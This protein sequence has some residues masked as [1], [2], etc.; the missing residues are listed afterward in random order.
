MNGSFHDRHNHHTNGYSDSSL[1]HPRTSRRTFHTTQC[2]SA[3]AGRPP[4]SP[5]PSY[6]HLFPTTC[7][8]PYRRQDESVHGFQ[9]QAPCATG[10]AS[11]LDSWQ[12]CKT[13]RCE[14]AVFDSNLN[15]AQRHR[16][17]RHPPRQ[18]QQDLRSMLVHPMASGSTLHDSML[19]AGGNCIRSD[20]APTPQ[21]FCFWISS[22]N[23]QASDDPADDQQSDDTTMLCVAVSVDVVPG[24]PQDSPR[25][26]IKCL[27]FPCCH[28]FVS[29]SSVMSEVAPLHLWL[30]SCD[31][32]YKESLRRVYATVAMLYGMSSGNEMWT[33][34][35]ESDDGVGT[36]TEEATTIPFH[37]ARK[38]C[39]V[40]IIGPH[41]LKSRCD[42]IPRYGPSHETL[43]V[44]FSTRGV[45]SSKDS[46]RTMYTANARDFSEPERGAV[47]FPW[48]S[49][50]V[51]HS[52]CA[53]ARL[54]VN[55]AATGWIRFVKASWRWAGGGVASCI[56]A[57]GPPLVETCEVPV[58]WYPSHGAP[59]HVPNPVTVFTV[60]PLSAS[61]H[62]K[63]RRE[64]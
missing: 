46:R 47:S 8:P 9:Q 6:D 63:K 38:C 20:A 61:M 41:E 50:P 29:R 40:H 26:H 35:T 28:A 58:Q 60:Y 17:Q 18:Q 45:T 13:A 51:A 53:F 11:K 4:P 48:L 7:P 30:R 19:L 21:H 33:I 5:P 49:G 37:I 62:R 39:E 25:L 23:A 34:T 54:L 57:K 55:E 42:D 31:T 2:R 14:E 44:S 27:H 64:L 10:N 12:R 1:P 24:P 43:V 32:E 16:D 22:S 59:L 15:R 3:A 56:D 36:T 52:Q